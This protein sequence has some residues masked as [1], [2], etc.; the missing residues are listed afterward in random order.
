MIFFEQI[1]EI[2][3]IQTPGGVWSQEWNLKELTEG[4]HQAMVT[5]HKQ[6]VLLFDHTLL[7]WLLATWIK[8]ACFA[9]VIQM[10][11]WE[12]AYIG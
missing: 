12:V 5:A 8:N 10:I 9:Y 2:L 11:R 7:S 4:H 6:F 3:S 1:R